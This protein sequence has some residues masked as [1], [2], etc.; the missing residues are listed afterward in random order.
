YFPDTNV[1]ITR[2]LS[3]DGVG[4][5][6]DFMYL[7]RG[8]GTELSTRSLIRRV[9]VVRGSMRFEV[10]CQPAFDYAREVHQ[11]TV[12]P[13]GALFSTPGLQLGLRTN[14]PLK[15][16]ETGVCGEFI[17]QAGQSA[18]FVLAPTVGAEALFPLV[19][20]EID[21]AF[22]ATVLFW[23]RWLS[24]CTYRGRWR[25]MGYRS[26]LALELLAYAP[27]GAIVAAGT[28]SLPETPGGHRN[29]DYRYTWIRDAAFTLYALL[30]IG[31]T[32]EAAQF[33]N[34]LEARCHELAPDGSLQIVYGI[35]GRHELPEQI[36]D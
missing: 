12:Q 5:L 24:H 6:T 1:L 30:R 13:N 21:Q 32:D 29:W 7:D 8:T 11:T 9:Q 10:Y 4:E 36:L 28:T 3:P 34:W 35:D 27:T 14:V 25:E 15:P 26:P 23:R 16:Q 22:Q 19:E 18:S 20:G 33:M 2:F 31:F 17:L